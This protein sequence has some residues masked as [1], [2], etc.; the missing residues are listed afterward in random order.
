VDYFWYTLLH[1]VI[2]AW[3]HVTAAEEAY[4]DR[5]ENMSSVDLAEKEAN[6]IARDTL[7][8]R[9]V[10]KRSQ[11]FL[12]PTKESIQELAHSLHVHP[13]II[14]GRLQFETGKYVAFRDL[15]GQGSIRKLFPELNFV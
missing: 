7:I 3:K 6:R 2:H 8:P 13:A 14:V 15:L 4:I 5:V 9:A 10:W 12:S 1:E 11:A